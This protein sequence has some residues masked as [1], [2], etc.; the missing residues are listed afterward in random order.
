MSAV[1]LIILLKD[2]FQE[3]YW[4]KINKFKRRKFK[5]LNKDNNGNSIVKKQKKI[6]LIRIKSDNMFGQFYFIFLF[7]SSPGNQ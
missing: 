7:F 5:V 2:Q 4:N 3:F 6:N 1:K